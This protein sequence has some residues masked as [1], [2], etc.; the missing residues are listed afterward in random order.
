MTELAQVLADSDL[1]LGR[2]ELFTGS[3]DLSR[4]IGR[5]TTSLAK[6]SPTRCAD[7][8]TTTDSLLP[9]AHV[10]PGPPGKGPSQMPLTR[11]TAYATW[12]CALLTLT[13]TS[14]A[15]AARASRRRR[16]RPG[17]RGQ[18]P[19]DHGQRQPG[20]PRERRGRP[21]LRL[22]RQHRRRHRLPRAPGRRRSSPSCRA[23]RTAVPRPPG[24]TP[25]ATGCWSPAPSPD[26]SSSTRTPAS[27]SP[28]T[29]SPTW[30]RKPWSTTRPSPPTGTST[31]PTPSAPSST[32]SRPPR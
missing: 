19:H 25:W 15:R 14:A 30:A 22:H 13:A 21:P 26:A 20:L 17:P 5:P 23:A 2:G 27:W 10:P 28:P 3:G 18:Q 24:S 12:R 31:S 16:A 6:L 32:G 29:P 1:G 7:G 4:L 8:P 9:F 11:T